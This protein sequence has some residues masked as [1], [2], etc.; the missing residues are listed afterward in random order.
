MNKNG[1]V[2]DG[3]S[4]LIEILPARFAGTRTDEPKKFTIQVA[5][6]GKHFLESPSV[7]L[8]VDN[9]GIREETEYAFTDKEDIR[10]VNC[11]LQ[12]RGHRKS[13]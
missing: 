6:D 3:N 13:P 7:V 5:L 9:T 1:A 2:G 10:T 12:R 8:R 4:Q 11:K